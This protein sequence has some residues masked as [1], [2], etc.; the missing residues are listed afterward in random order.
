MSPNVDE[1]VD[2][3]LADKPPAQTP[4]KEFAAETLPTLESHLAQAKST[5]A[6]VGAGSAS[7]RSHSALTVPAAR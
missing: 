1:L 4:A 5:A 2:R 3:L 6:K 7:A